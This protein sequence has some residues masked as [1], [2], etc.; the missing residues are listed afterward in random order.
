[1]AEDEVGPE[2]RLATD[3]LCA[4]HLHDRYT[5][6]PEY[7]ALLRG[8]LVA[9]KVPEVDL[10]VLGLPVS[11]FMAKKATI[12]KLDVGTHDVG[13]GRKVVVRKVMV[14]A[15]PQGALMYFADLH[16]KMASIEHEQSLVI[17][18]GMRTFDWA[19]PGCS[20]PP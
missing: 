14:L 13:S 16:Q 7:L 9:M 2:V 19:P 6:T 10:L 8:A 20:G 5:E 1:V 11:H 12:E 17:D 18:A 4:T 3:N 15:Q